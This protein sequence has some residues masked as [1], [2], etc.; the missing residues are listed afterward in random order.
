ML[1]VAPTRRVAFEPSEAD[2][3]VTVL[4]LAKLCHWRVAHFGVAK[5]DT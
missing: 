4:E 5:T 1:K 2:F 3:L